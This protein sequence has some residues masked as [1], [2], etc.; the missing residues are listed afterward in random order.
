MMQE[1]KRREK[2][3]INFFFSFFSL[4]RLFPDMMEWEKSVDNCNDGEGGRCLYVT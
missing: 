2:I 1:K 4:W 3:W